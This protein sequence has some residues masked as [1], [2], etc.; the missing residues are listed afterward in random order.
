MSSNE[1]TIRTL[2]H[3]IWEAEGKPDG[4]SDKHWERATILASGA[5]DE[6][7]PELKRSIDPSEATGPTEPAQP[8]QT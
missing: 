6:S 2:A 1:E 8:D 4:Q 5:G 3:Q 7:K